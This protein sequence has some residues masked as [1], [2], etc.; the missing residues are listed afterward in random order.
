MQ[1]PDLTTNIRRQLARAGLTVA[2]LARRSGLD[3]RTLKSLLRG[4]A[5]KPHARTLHRLALGLGVSVDELL[6]PPGGPDEFD[7]LTNPLV[8]EVIAE[9]PVVFHNWTAADYRDLYSRMGTGGPLTRDGALELAHR[10]NSR[11]ELLEKVALVWETGEGD[12][13]AGLVD[14]LYRRV[15][16]LPETAAPPGDGEGD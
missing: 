16:L 14:V 7:R 12:L 8:A 13:L 4:T 15:Q 5:G 3:E 2:E 6:I 1:P 10:L 9:H 11:R